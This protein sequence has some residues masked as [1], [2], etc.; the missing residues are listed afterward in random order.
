MWEKA[1]SEQVMIIEFSKGSGRGAGGAMT[2]Q[3]RAFCLGT[4]GFSEWG[5]GKT[6]WEQLTGIDCLLSVRYLLGAL[7]T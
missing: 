3:G 2:E 4:G 5:L 1:A 7:H 6:Y